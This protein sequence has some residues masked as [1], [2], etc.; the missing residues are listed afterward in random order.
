MNERALSLLY[1]IGNVDD[2]L[3]AD[4]KKKPNGYAL[5]MKI[6]ACVAIALIPILL[7][8]KL[9]FTGAKAEDP[10]YRDGTVCVYYTDDDGMKR[11]VIV[12]G[13][14]DDVDEVFALWCGANGIGDVELY[15]FDI[16]DENGERTAVFTVSPEFKPYMNGERLF[17][18][19]ET[20]RL[21]LDS[22]MDFMLDHDA[23]T[24]RFEI[25]DAE[26]IVAGGNET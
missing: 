2:G 18:L 26:N 6:A 14:R 22:N 5:A 13:R 4:A 1:A 7:W 16:K 20:L 21:T 8:A 3:F 23:D 9:V 15:G 25:S 19:E 24:L 17:D 12:N 10:T 11:S